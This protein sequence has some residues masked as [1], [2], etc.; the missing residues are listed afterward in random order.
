MC[1]LE[2]SITYQ[3]SLIGIIAF[4]SYQTK[5]LRIEQI[6]REEDYYDLTLGKLYSDDVRTPLLSSFNR[7]GAEG[8][9][10]HDGH[11]S[12]E[13]LRVWKSK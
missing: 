6:G 1:N 5:A 3:S 13:V 2:W 11:A 9:R 4:D 7:C 10:R 8:Q 12:Q